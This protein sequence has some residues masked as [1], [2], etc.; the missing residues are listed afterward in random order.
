MSVKQR[1]SFCAGFRTPATTSYPRA[2]EAGVRKPPRHE[3][4]GNRAATCRGLY[5]ALATGR[6][7]QGERFVRAIRL[8]REHNLSGMARILL[9]GD[10]TFCATNDSNG[11]RVAKRAHSTTSA[12]GALRQ[13]S[14]DSR[15]RLIREDFES[16]GSPEPKL[17]CCVRQDSRGVHSW[18]RVSGSEFC[19]TNVNRPLFGFRCDHCG[20][21][22]V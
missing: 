2:P 11:L 9:N 14:N 15:A 13:A 18:D 7:S 16:L 19:L 20:S 1:F 5:R 3:I 17:F 6:D 10:F 4:A 21:L 22:C 8:E 12:R